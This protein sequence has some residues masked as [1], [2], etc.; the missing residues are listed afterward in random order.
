MCTNRISSNR[1]SFSSNFLSNFNLNSNFSLSQQ[2]RMNRRSVS[3][4]YSNVPPEAANPPPEP[5]TPPIQ[6]EPKPN[7]APPR[8]R[9]ISEEHGDAPK[10]TPPKNP[11]QSF[12]QYQE[13]VLPLKSQPQIPNNSNPKPSPPRR[14]LI[15]KP[16]PK[17]DVAI[18]SAPSVNIFLGQ[19]ESMTTK[20]AKKN[21][22]DNLHLRGNRESV[23]GV[24]NDSAS[25]DDDQVNVKLGDREAGGPRL[26]LYTP[27]LRIRQTT[28]RGSHFTPTPR[29]SP[30]SQ[31]TPHGSQ[32]T[33]RGPQFALSNALLEIRSRTEN[34]DPSDPLSE[35]STS[36]RLPEWRSKIRQIAGIQDRNEP[37]RD[38]P[39]SRTNSEIP[40]IGGRPEWR[41]KARQDRNVSEHESLSRAGESNI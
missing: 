31:L 17:N 5:V 15:S 19:P 40:G 30:L 18:G 9:R 12:R 26:S 14:I 7:H 13:R 28:P 22:T 36:P 3:S 34:P 21:D 38:V 33:P 16:N 24:V 27:L 41:T 29:G 37:V 6:T 32:T 20:D 8:Q 25:D 23:K 39:L 1:T 11:K 10:K 4:N 35:F 2:E